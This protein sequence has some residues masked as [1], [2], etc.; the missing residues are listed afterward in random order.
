MTLG[1]KKALASV[2]IIVCLGLQTFE[3]VRP[4]WV[5]WPAR[6]WPFLDYPMFS[7][8]FQP[9]ATARMIELRAV[10]C[11]AS[12]GARPIAASE[13]GQPGFRMRDRLRTIAAEGEGAPH[14]RSL[15]S[16]MVAAEIVP[17]PCELQVWELAVTTTADGVDP[18]E[19]TPQRWRMRRAWRLESPQ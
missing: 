16:R 4:P 7:R 17:R 8:S 9:G 5:S 13:I 6:F 3:I 12:R 10:S 19:F 14:Q 15:L 2:V 11:E 18:A 1:T